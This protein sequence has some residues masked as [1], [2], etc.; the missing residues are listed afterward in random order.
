M[1]SPTHTHTRTHTHTH[2]HTHT[3][4]Q[5]NKQTNN[6]IKQTNN[7]Q[8]IIIVAYAVHCYV[9]FCSVLLYKTEL[10]VIRVVNSNA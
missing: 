8:T 10:R 1:V 7:K 4:K 9:L 5:T 6:K 2:T 3:N